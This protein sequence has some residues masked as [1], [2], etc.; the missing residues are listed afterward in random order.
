MI[1]EL[2]L[3]HPLKIEQHCLLSNNELMCS[4]GF[5]LWLAGGA[6]FYSDID[7]YP[8]NWGAY[9]RTL[10]FL[11]KYGRFIGSS[12]RSVSYLYAEDTW[13]LIQPAQTDILDLLLTADLSPCATA[14]VWDVDH[15]RIYT[16]YPDDIAQRVCR[17][18]T[19]HDWTTYRLEVYHKKGYTT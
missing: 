19:S 14:L 7:L 15:F 3:V 5:P 2:P 10:N 11:G 4:G 16:L 9:Y 18:L 13:Q 12:P 17:V 8:A 6:N 1:A